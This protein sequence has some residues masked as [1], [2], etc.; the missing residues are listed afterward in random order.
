MKN[1]IDF[2]AK[3]LSDGHFEVEY[4]AIDPKYIGKNCRISIIRHI[5]VKIARGNDVKKKLYS[6]N[7][8][9]SREMSSLRSKVFI[10]NYEGDKIRIE[11][12]LEV[13][14]DDHIFVDSTFNLRIKRDMYADKN[15]ENFPSK[16]LLDPKDHFR[17][18]TNLF[19]LAPKQQMI[20][21]VL[22][23]CALLFVAINTFIGIHDQFVVE[24]LTWIYSHYDSD[25]ESQSPIIMSLCFSGAFGG[26]VWTFILKVFKKYMSFYIRPVPK[27]LTAETLI[28]SHE[29]IEGYS[30]TD[31]RDIRIRVVAG[32]YESGSYEEG[33]GS[34]QR[35]VHFKRAVNGVTL[36]E[37]KV[38]HLPAGE[39]LSSVLEG[40]IVF[41]LLFENLH[42][43]IISS[44]IGLEVHWEVQLIHNQLVDQEVVCDFCLFP[45]EE[46]KKVA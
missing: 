43:Q 31:L 36:F 4:K 46:F 8:S 27:K 28:P 44:G 16:V 19:T 37:Q 33:S 32:N 26:L 20:V 5:D 29:F 14:V 9:L 41:K 17:F 24:S 15:V 11:H 23:F 25:G 40:D 39:P 7:V 30:R 13:E 6:K 3:Y 34:D 22:L 35:T 38:K 1:K 18:M 21:L 10:E 42:P 12:Y 45:V 2:K